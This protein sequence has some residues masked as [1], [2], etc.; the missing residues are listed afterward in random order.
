MDFKTGED[1]HW[2]GRFLWSDRPI[3]FGE[4]HPTTKIL[5]RRSAFLV[6]PSEAWMWMV[7][8]GRTSEGS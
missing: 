8:P 6:G 5:V 3:T 4:N 1:S 7:F 2:S